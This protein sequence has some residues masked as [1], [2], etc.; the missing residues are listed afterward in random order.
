MVCFYPIT[1]AKKKLQIKYDQ[2]YSAGRL[3][4]SHISFNV[5]NGAISQ[6]PSC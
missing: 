4:I 2:S 5:M 6:K 3:Q 1:K